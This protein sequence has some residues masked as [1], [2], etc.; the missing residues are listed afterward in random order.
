MSAQILRVLTQFPFEPEEVTRLQSAVTE[1]E[2]EIVLCRTEA[3]FQSKLSTAEVVFGLCRGSDLARAP[4][5]RWIQSSAAGVDNLDPELRASSIVLTNY[6]GAFAPGIAETTLGLLLCLTRGL[7]R[8]YVP[9][10]LRREW[11]P[12][13][14]AKSGDHVEISGRTMGIV[15]LGGIG[16]AIARTAHYGFNMRVIAT[17]VRLD[18]CPEYV[19]ELHPPD[20]FT[21]MIPQA[22]VLVAAA[23]L[24]PETRGIFNEDVFRRMKS[25]AYFLAVSRGPLYDDMA[26]VKALKENWIAG[27]GLDVFPVEP[28]PPDHPIFDC[29]NVVMSMHTSGWGPDRQVRLIEL[30]CENLRRYAHGQELLNIVNKKLGF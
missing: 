21:D 22:D 16:R 19:A 1:R 28:P 26:L 11:K 13:G 4:M 18:E 24:T 3:E 23:P 8:Y 10:F 30:F 29:P 14:T 15:G 12:V 6:A 2:V 5:L 7:S 25:T 9:Q 27:A 17:D 20:W